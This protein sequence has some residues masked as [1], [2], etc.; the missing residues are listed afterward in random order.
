MLQRQGEAAQRQKF[1]LL[2]TSLPFVCHVVAM[3][4]LLSLPRIGG[5][6]VV[7]VVVVVVAGGSG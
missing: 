7:V 3:L 5:M 1:I 6:V 2:I 4:W